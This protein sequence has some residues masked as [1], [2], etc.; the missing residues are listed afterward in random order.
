MS[1]S[2]GWRRARARGSSSPTARASSA[3]GVIAGPDEDV[4]CLGQA[5]QK[6]GAQERRLADPGRAADQEELRLAEPGQELVDKPLAAEEE[7]RV[8]RL[9]RREALERAHAGCGDGRSSC[10]WLLRDAQAGLLHEDRTLELLQIDAGLEAE[11]VVQEPPRVPIEVETLG[12]TATAVEREHQLPTE[13]LAIRVVGDHGLELGDEREVSSEREL[14]VD[15][16]LDRRQEELVEPLGLNAHEPLHL[17]IRERPACPELLGCA[18]R[19]RCCRRVAACE[20]LAAVGGEPLEAL[21]V[22]LSG[23]DPEQV[24]GW[25]RDQ[26]RLVRRHGADELAKPRDVVVYGVPGRVRALV[27]EELAAQPLPRQDAVGA[28]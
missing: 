26:A 10:A 23:L 13:A 19:R 8:G 1:R 12:L 3:S 18:E 28:Q 20:R 6:P 9:E 27:G 2:P 21:Q 24:A 16:A 25:S 22:E 11:L 7:R 5:R 14:S 15:P 4:T 17:E